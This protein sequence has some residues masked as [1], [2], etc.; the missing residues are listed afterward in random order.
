MI[1]LKL[2]SAGYVSPVLCQDIVHVVRVPDTHFL[3][4]NTSQFQYS[5]CICKEDLEPVASFRLCSTVF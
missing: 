5:V 1:V 4:L 2:F 3:M